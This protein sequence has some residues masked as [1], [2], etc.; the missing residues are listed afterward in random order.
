MICLI[1]VLIAAF[2]AITASEKAGFVTVAIVNNDSTETGRAIVSSLTEKAMT[3]KYTEYED[4][5]AALSDLDKQKVDAVWVLP[6]NIEERINAFVEAPSEKNYIA[7]VY[8]KENNLQVRLPLEQLTAAIYPFASGQ[9]YLKYVRENPDFDLG[10]LSDDV[11]YRYYED[12]VNKADLFEFSYPAGT[13]ATAENENNYLVYPI[14][15][16]L[17]IL[18]VICGFASAMYFIA[19]QKRGTY[20][21]VKVSGRALISFA[22]QFTAVINLGVFVFASV[23]ILGVNTSAL[24]ETLIFAVFVVN[25]TLFCTVLQQLFDNMIIFVSLATLLTVLQ[26]LICPVFF[27]YSIQKIPQLIF[28]NTYYIN[29]VHSN[30]YLAYSFVYMAVLSAVFALIYLRKRKN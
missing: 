2:S 14:R 19:D 7:G 9:F 5:S 16:I 20:S 25:V 11:V 30:L 18:T 27:N 4:E 22:S 21:R 12:Y 10:E 29:S 23:F 8:I 26:A 24:R 17:S 15:G 3:I 6:E 28:P 13:S 1:P